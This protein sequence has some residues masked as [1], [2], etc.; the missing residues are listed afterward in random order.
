MGLA[1]GRSN[2]GSH[3][4]GCI[5]CAKVSTR[6]GDRLN[7]HGVWM[8]AVLSCGDGA[9]L[10]HESA[11]ALLGIRADP[12]RIEVST[13]TDRRRPGIVI[14]RRADLAVTRHHGIPVT[15]PIFTL[16]DLGARLP[17]DELEAAIN[18]ADKRDLVDP[19]TLRSALEKMSRRPG[20]RMLRETLD[21]RTFTLTDSGLERRF[22][23]IARRV[24]LPLPETGQIVNGYKVDFYWPD[25]GLVVE[26]DGLQYHRTP[27][28]QVKDRLRDQAHTAAGLTPLRFT[29][30]QVRY[31]PGHVEE[32]L[33]AV[34][35][36][37]LRRAD[38]WQT[39][40]GE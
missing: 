26:T 40:L 27:A 17:R 11:G 6:S 28:Q 24:G 3:G 4:A 19:D 34:A 32:T 5:G 23:P 21:R 12:G 38:S 16:V 35:H 20:L 36:R 7:R 30:A 29:R 25:L 8:A 18:A 14:H 39:P 37:L 1:R 15:P 10:S 33:A 22:L 9:A 2:I 31:E 13:R